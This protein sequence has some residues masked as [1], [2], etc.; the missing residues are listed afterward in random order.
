M[1]PA[2]KES[3][4]L[5]TLLIL[6]LWLVARCGRERSNTLSLPQSKIPT[7]GNC[8]LGDLPLKIL[9]VEDEPGKVSLSYNLP[10]Y[11]RERHGLSAELVQNIA[12]VEA[13]VTKAAE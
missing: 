2:T 11:L 10:A 3:S 12:I 9:V 13:L 1:Q 5:C 7:A 6:L 8:A 4:V